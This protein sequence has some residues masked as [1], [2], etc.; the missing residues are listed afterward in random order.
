M[1]KTSFF[2]ASL[3]L[4]EIYR[5]F[6]NLYIEEITIMPQKNLNLIPEMSFFVL[7]TVNCFGHEV[8]FLLDQ[9]NQN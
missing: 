4:L 6:L 3:L 9:L 5:T 7:L 2:T 8:G 1:T